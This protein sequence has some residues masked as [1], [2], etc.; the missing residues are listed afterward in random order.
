MVRFEFGRRRYF[1]D[2]SIV[3]VGLNGLG[4]V[5]F[6]YANITGQFLVATTPESLYVTG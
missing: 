2:Y 1:V 4:V 6:R 5:S 3:F